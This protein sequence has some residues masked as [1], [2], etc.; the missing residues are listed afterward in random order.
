MIDTLKDN[1][2]KDTI[3]HVTTNRPENDPVI[4]YIVDTVP[5]Y[6]YYKE[7]FKDLKSRC[8]YMFHC[9]EIDTA[10]EWVIKTEIDV[11]FLRKLREFNQI[12]E[13]DIDVAIQPEN[14][15]IYDDNVLETRLWRQIYRAMDIK[16]PELMLPY[17]ENQEFGRPLLATGVVA[18]K[19]KH[20]DKIN[21]RWVNLTKICERWIDYGIHPNE[22]AFTGLIFDEEWDFK[23]YNRKY[24]FN[25]IGH[26]RKGMYPS[27]KLVDDCKL[28]SETIVFDY[29][30]PQWLY[31]VSRFNPEIRNIIQRNL[32]HIPKNW[33]E[34]DIEKFFEEEVL[35]NVWKDFYR[36]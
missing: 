4:K 33:W 3:L 18:V 10:K 31:H 30:R 15:R 23:L 21:E 19:S 24:N 12:L 13:K 34:T 26:F 35:T 27:V 28:P 16:M 7:P 29:H 2:P 25:P 32:E 9:F 11:L 6:L 22:F 36:K 1:I 14:R 17:V 8:Q 5:T 20:L